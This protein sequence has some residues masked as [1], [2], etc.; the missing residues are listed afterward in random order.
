MKTR[1][2]LT[3]LAAFA[4]VCAAQEDTVFASQDNVGH[5]RT[6]G[7]WWSFADHDTPPS[8]AS[9]FPGSSM[10]FDSTGYWIEKN[11]GLLDITYKLSYPA[12]GWAYY[13]IGFNF[14]DPE[15]D[16]PQTW[17][18]IC[19]DYKLAFTKPVSGSIPAT[20][21]FQLKNFHMVT[22]DN[23]YEVTLSPSSTFYKGCFGRS[24]FTQPRPE[25]TDGTVHPIDTLLSILRGI[26]FVAGGKPKLGSTQDIHFV[27]KSITTKTEGATSL[28]TGRRAD[29]GFVVS[30]RTLV[31]E[32]LRGS[33]KVELMD[34]SGRIL[35]SRWSTDGL[36]IQLPQTA[37]GIFA[38]RVSNGSRTSTRHIALP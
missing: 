14:T 33:A 5:C 29:F 37:R 20:L 2:I 19:V 6:G 32:G 27:L 12:L 36:K 31:L 38:I 11:G 25:D 18:S 23:D 13:G 9:D 24:D 26:K 34:L 8:S 30:G 17:D 4:G 10:T 16:T 21:K 22:H 15:E 1:Q 35:S 3:I 7:Y 28:R